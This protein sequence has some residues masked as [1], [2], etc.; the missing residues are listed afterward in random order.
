MDA[1][2]EFWFSGADPDKQVH[3]F[4]MKPHGYQEGKRYGMIFLV[5]GGPQSAWTDS[6]STRW[7][8]NCWTA[9][10]YVAV[11]INPTGSTG[12]GQEFVNAIN[13]NWGGSPFKD[14]VAGLQFVKRVYGDMIDTERMAMAGGS[15]GGYMCNWMQGHNDILGFKAFICHDGI[16]DTKN[17]YFGTEELY[18]AEHDM[19]GAPWEV[20]QT[21]ERWSPHN[22]IRNWKTPELV[23]HGGLDYRL[24][25][26]EAIGMFNALQRKGVPSKFV[27]FPKENHWVLNPLNSR[28]WYQEVLGWMDEWIGHGP[29]D[30]KAARY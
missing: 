22:H 8:P 20:P 24:P 25:D 15:Y 6:W 21:Y 9:A 7:N 29:S 12:Y 28:R 27:Y 2:E 30:G 3:G 11:M 1:G 10:G 4:I 19:G 23:I 16:L 14:L 13:Q 17:A 26:T 18:F 5:H